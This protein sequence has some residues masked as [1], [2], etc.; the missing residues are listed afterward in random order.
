MVHGVAS[1]TVDDR[2][3][4]DILAVMDENS[5]EIDEYEEGHVGEFLEWEYVWEYVVGDALGE[6]VERVE[7]V[8]RKGCGH[9]PLVVRFVQ[10][11][12]DQRM[13]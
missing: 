6:S 2:R 11:F 3:V 13:V 10:A 9:D 5:P 12:V 4:G 1:G 8:A 7:G